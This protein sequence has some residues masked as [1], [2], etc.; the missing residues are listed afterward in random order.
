LILIDSSDVPVNLSHA[1]KAHA[2]SMLRTNSS[3]GNFEGSIDRPMRLAEIHVAAENA[4]KKTVSNPDLWKS[5]SSVADFE[6]HACI[7][8]MDAIAVSFLVN[9]Y[10][11][12]PFVWRCANNSSSTC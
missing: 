1:T 12:S 4:L 7:Y 10:K 8:F 6:V 9:F 3:P 2:A 5:L 11:N